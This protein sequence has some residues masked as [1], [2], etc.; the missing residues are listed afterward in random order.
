M[1]SKST[2]YLLAQLFFG[3][4]G[5]QCSSTLYL[6]WLFNYYDLSVTDE[7]FMETKRASGV[8]NYMP[9]TFDNYLHH[10]VDGNA[11]G[12]FVPEDEYIYCLQKYELF[13]ILRIFLSQA[14]P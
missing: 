5:P 9:G 2:S 4:L 8:S 14:V 10:W 11:G 12:S 13:E 1:S 7:S 6:F 3:I